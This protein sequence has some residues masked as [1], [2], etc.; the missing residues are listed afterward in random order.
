LLFKKF[1]LFPLQILST[2]RVSPPKTPYPIPPASMRVLPHSPT[3]HSLPWHFPTL[4]HQTFTG[5]MASPP[6]DAQPDPLEL[7]DIKPPTKEY[8]WRDPWL[9]PHM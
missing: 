9:Y 6:I 8:T 7:P 3:P 4:G 2:F 1:S 5:P